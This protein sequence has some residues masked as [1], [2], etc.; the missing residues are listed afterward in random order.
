MLTKIINKKTIIIMKS[1]YL[2]TGVVALA[3]LSGCIKEEG[4][5]FLVKRTEVCDSTVVTGAGGYMEGIATKDSIVENSFEAPITDGQIKDLNCYT[6]L[7]SEFQ[8]LNT[9][10]NGIMEV[11]YVY[12]HSN[13]LP[14]INDKENCKVV[15]VNKNVSPSDAKVTFDGILE[16]LDFNSTYYV[17]SYAVCKGDGKSD[18]VIYNGR[19]LEYNTVLPEDVWVQRNDAPA[20]MLGRQ[21]AFST[22]VDIAGMG[23]ENERA[24][25]PKILPNLPPSPST[26]ITKP[27]R[28]ATRGRRSGSWSASTYA[29]R[30][31]ACRKR[32]RPSSCCATGAA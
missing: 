5:E 2:F 18:S 12:S 7:H 31:S 21:F 29:A 11:G 8:N 32:K 20:T 19:T 24:I 15:V 25:L 14:V 6:I 17:R 3:L 28:S 23:L 26:I 10:R 9:D 13:K 30:W 27:F 22:R 16:G 4:D 1:K